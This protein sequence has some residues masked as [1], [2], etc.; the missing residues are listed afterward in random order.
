MVGTIAANF[1]ALIMLTFHTDLGFLT[2]LP[3]P[4][5]DSY[6]PRPLLLQITSD[7][8]SILILVL[9]GIV[10]GPVQERMYLL[11]SS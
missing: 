7:C 2:V 1:S 3:G 4:R 10:P 5:R 11:G 9:V 8:I 6:T